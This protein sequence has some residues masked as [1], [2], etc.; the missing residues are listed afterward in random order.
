MHTWYTDFSFTVELKES[1]AVCLLVFIYFYTVSP[2]ASDSHKGDLKKPP[3][4][5]F[6]FKVYPEVTVVVMLLIINL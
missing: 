6:K 1:C 2:L 5:G 3:W 4:Y